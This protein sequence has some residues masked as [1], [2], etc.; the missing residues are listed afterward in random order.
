MSLRPFSLPE[1]AQ[2]MVKIIAQSAHYPDHEEWDLDAESLQGMESMAKQIKRFGWVLRGLRTIFPPL[3]TFLRGFIWVE[4][5][6]DVGLSNLM[7][8]GNVQAWMIVNVAV[9]PEYR[10]RGIA[11]RV[12]E[13]CIEDARSL[14]AEKVVLDVI[15]GNLSAYTLYETLGFQRFS[16][17][18]ELEHGGA[19]DFDRPQWSKGYRLDGRKSADW[20]AVYAFVKGITP[21]EVQV[22][23]PVE[24]LSFR[25]LAPLSMASGLLQRLAGFRT[26]RYIVR[27]EADGRVVG[28]AE[29]SLRRRAKGAV[30]L[31]VQV[32]PSHLEVAAD[33]VQ[34][35]L[36]EIGQHAGGRSIKLSVKHWQTGLAEV[37]QTLGFVRKVD[38]I[39]MGLT[40]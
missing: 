10:R 18:H 14:Q 37:C 3:K 16:G 31:S 19:L 36:Y 38:Y 8:Q 9:V 23:N 5:G 7:R 22:Y 24:M 39:S 2:S 35:M 17:S 12:V 30:R 34:T 28:L 4:D 25:Q 6:Q 15:D 11:R 21:S 40:L 33:L 13:A 26:K 32:D 29:Y 20:Q 1:D 27:R